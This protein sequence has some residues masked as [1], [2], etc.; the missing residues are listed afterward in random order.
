MI[1]KIIQ[2]GYLF[3]AVFFGYETFR[4]WNEDRSKAYMLLVFAILAVFMFFFKKHFR[5]KMDAQ[6]RK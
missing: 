5:K 1:Q 2:Y 4:Q 6:N 3:V